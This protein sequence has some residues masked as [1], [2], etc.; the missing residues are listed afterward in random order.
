MTSSAN[1]NLEQ[2]L[3]TLEAKRDT[4]EAEVKLLTCEINKG[5]SILKKANK[6]KGLIY[7]G[8]SNSI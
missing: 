1:H 3:K 8:S 6:K 4:L 7:R 5:R 2:Q